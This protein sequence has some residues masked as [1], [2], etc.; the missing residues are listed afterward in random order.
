MNM[1]TRTVRRLRD[2]LVE[3]GG[4]VKDAAA[5]PPETDR[6]REASLKRVEPFL[7]T[8]YL[9]MMADGQ[10]DVAEQA[11]MRGALR[12]LTQG[13]IDT[14]TLESLLRTFAARLGQQGLEHR[15]QAIGGVVCANKRDRETALTLA[16]AIALADHAVAG[17]E[18][19]LV[20]SIAEWFGVSRRRC[21]ELLAQFDDDM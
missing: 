12:I 7:E 4:A 6:G 9:M 10:S 3:V 18:G 15:L 21:L 20:S 19:E 13:L 2:A 16:A 8:M 5:D 11:A 17:E 1:D 14:G